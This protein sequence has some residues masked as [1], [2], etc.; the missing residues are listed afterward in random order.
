MAA[1]SGGRRPASPRGYRLPEIFP[2]LDRAK[3]ISIDLESVDKWIGE[4]RG[5][6]WRRD[7]YIV[8]FALAIENSKGV[9]NFSE[10]FPLRHKNAPNLD[11][12]RVWDWLI[13]ELSFYTGEIVGTN[14]LYDMDGFSYEGLT[15]PFAK[16][17][18]MLSVIS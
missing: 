6:G 10:Y 1:M 7:A 17:R 15:A 4:K 8:G 5:P 3:R 11:A 13:T 2:S 9:I 18:D 16:F 14:L 12:V